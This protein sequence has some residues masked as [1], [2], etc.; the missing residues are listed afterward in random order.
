MN[1]ENLSDKLIPV[2]LTGVVSF[3]FAWILRGIDRNRSFKDKRIEHAESTI[4]HFSK[5]VENWRKLITI[6]KLQLEREL[7]TDEK[8]RM[9]EYIRQRDDARNSLIS[10]INTL[11]LF[12]EEVVVNKF[13]MFKKWDKEQSAKRLDELP[14]VEE[15]EEW[16]NCLAELLRK[17]IQ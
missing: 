11:P 8:D 15:W 4:V 14:T 2:I 5:Y 13:K 3:I 10:N 7:T 6:A 1:F 9:R 12:F 16:L 17:H